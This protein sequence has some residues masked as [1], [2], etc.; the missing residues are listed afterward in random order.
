MTFLDWGCDPLTAEC[1]AC[2]DAI[3][4]MCSDAARNRGH[5]DSDSPGG[6]DPDS[7]EPDCDRCDREK[8]ADCSRCEMILQVCLL[9]PQN[10]G[11]EY[12]ISR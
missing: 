10:P 3:C 7:Y 11:C 4:N 5:R 1:E 12:T 2:L 9:C 8:K 6:D